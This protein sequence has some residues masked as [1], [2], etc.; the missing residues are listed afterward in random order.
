MPV[1][2]GCDPG[3]PVKGS[4]LASGYGSIPRQTFNDAGQKWDWS[5]PNYMYSA[6][7]VSSEDY[8]KF[9]AFM[10]QEMQKAKAEK[11]KS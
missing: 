4:R 8:D 7:E 10:M 2:T 6:F 3:S 9:N 11:K 5:N 1:P